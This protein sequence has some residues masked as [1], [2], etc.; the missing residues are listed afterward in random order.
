MSNFERKY[1]HD[2]LV[3]LLV[4]V[5]LF[6]TL[7]ASLLVL[8]K[9]DSG[10]NAGYIIQYRSNLG[11]GA[12]KAGSFSEIVAFV[13]FGLIIM[14]THTFLSFRIYKSNRYVSLMI[15]ALALVLLVLQVVVSGALL[16]TSG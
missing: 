6:V 14:L 15:L 2:R 9:I 8:L 10:R 3:L 1:F 13:V 4:S 16:R 12:P 11:I 5:N 7:A